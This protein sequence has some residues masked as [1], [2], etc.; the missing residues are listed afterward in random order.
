MLAKP[1]SG[2]F[3]GPDKKGEGMKAKNHLSE[4]DEYVKANIALERLRREQQEL[5][6]RFEEIAFQLS[7]P[8]KTMDAQAAWE[9]ALDDKDF[10]V[11]DQPSPLRE[12]F[13]QLESR[14]RFVNQA[15][16]HGMQVLDGVVGR[17]SSEICAGIRKEWVGHIERILKSLKVI[18]EANT[19]LDQMR[20]A[21]E[22]Q[23]VRTDSL[24]YA[25]FDLGGEWSDPMGGK[26]V[27]YQRFV[28][29]NYPELSS[30]AGMAVKTKLAA[31]AERERKFAEGV[32]DE[33]I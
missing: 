13:Q 4:F 9:L 1:G 2:N 8:K 16:D 17:C 3:S 30:A 12:E 26:V 22:A 14:L 29:E 11:N 15:L 25:K 24:H 33:S 23:G 19:S 7:Q 20:D 18:C 21:L 31:L 6:R 10:Q 32:I 5:S 28:S 27:G